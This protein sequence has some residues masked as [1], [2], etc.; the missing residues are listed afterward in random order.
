[1][2]AL[3]AGLVLAALCQLGDRTP[4]L[5]AILGDRYRA[6]GVVIAAVALALA[7]NYALGA[8]GGILLAPLLAP[9]ARGMLLALALVL[10]GVGTSWRDKAPDRL[11]NWQLG[12]IATSVLGLAIM[13]LGDRMQFIVAALAARSTLPW[14]AA[15]GATLG[16]LAVTVPAILIG[17]ARWIALPRRAISLATGACMILAGIVIGLQSIALI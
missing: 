5:A 6:P 16:A 13:V 11:A 12:A 9:E 7:G 17:E 14:L 15:V 3:M 8:L 2:D 4:W 10:A 1:M